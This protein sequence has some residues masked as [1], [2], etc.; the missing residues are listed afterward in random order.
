MLF[1]QVNEQPLGDFGV[2]DR[3]RI[4]MYSIDRYTIPELVEKSSVRYAERTALS[5][6]QGEAVLF[7]DLEPRTRRVSALLGLLGIKKGDR[8]ALLS[9]NRPEWGLAYLGISRTGAIAVPIMTDFTSEQIANI[10]AHSES[11]VLIVSR[12]LLAKIVGQEAKRI[13]VSVESLELVSAPDGF[14]FPTK[15][16]IDAAA[17]AFAS[18]P[19]Q[20]DDLASIVYTS[21]TTGHSKGVMLSHRNIVF[22]AIASR[23]L[24]HTYE[25]TIG[26]IIPLMQGSAVYYLDRPPSATVLLPAM[27]AIRPTVF[28]SVPLLIEKTYRS[29]VKPALDKISLYKIPFLRPLFDRIAGLKLLKNF[30]GKI[31]FF[32][33]G[34]APLAADVESF[35]SSARFP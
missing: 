24:A 33:I 27:A 35:L 19:I 31:R 21:G 3:R 1:S 23:P 30:G 20:G 34:G 25:F 4:L 32:G 12:R 15:D 22:D 5:M 26:F 2:N 14:S 29:A 9:E 11:S 28:L 17:A 6:V 13:I 16:R 7:R 10:L 8:V 18:P